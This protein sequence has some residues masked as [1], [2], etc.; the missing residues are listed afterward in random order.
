MD[1][2]QPLL[3]VVLGIGVVAV[4]VRGLTIDP[5]R[6]R[7]V[8]DTALK[9]V[10]GTGLRPEPDTYTPQRSRHTDWGDNP[11]LIERKSAEAVDPDGSREPV[12]SGIL[13]DSQAPSAVID[14]QVVNPGDWVEGWQVVEIQKDQVVLTDRTARKTIRVE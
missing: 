8:S 5:V 7:R 14:G 11:F 13:W 10:S 3:L 12:V 1:K 6:S 4:W 2:K 9:T